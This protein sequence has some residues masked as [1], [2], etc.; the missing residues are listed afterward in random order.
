MI[1]VE[2][3]SISKPSIIVTPAFYGT[4]TNT[5]CP[6]KV[7]LAHY[8]EKIIKASCASTSIMIIKV[9]IIT[10]RNHLFKY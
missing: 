3:G 10:T 8:K 9:V 2:I 6:F 7:C 4:Q 1:D 5:C